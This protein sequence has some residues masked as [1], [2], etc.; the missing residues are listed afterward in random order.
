MELIF[1][2]CTLTGDTWGTKQII[3]N[4]ETALK[5]T[6]TEDHVIVAYL[7]EHPETVVKYP[8]AKK[9]KVK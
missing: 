9:R 3:T 6:T 5:P 2:G 1:V 8:F 7:N 4:I